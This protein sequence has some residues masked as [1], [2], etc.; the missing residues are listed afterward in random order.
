MYDV[1]V[2]EPGSLLLLGTGLAGLG[3]ML[4]RKIQSSLL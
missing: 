3:I 4:R 2:P 1:R